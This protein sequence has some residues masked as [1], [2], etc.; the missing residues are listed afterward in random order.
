LI[1]FSLFN[2]LGYENINVD[3]F[4]WYERTENFF[5]AIKE[6]DFSDT[7]QQYHPGV[8]LMYLIRLGQLSYRISTGDFSNHSDIS[9]ENYGLYNYHTKL[10]VVIFCLLIILFSSHLVNK[11][12]KSKF[13]AI[14]FFIFLLLESYYIGI[15]RNLHMDGI[16]SVLIFSSILSF[17]LA[18]SEKSTKYFILSGIL[19]GLGFLT[20]SVSFFIPLFCLIIFIV[21]LIK[22][23]NSFSLFMRMG[24][25]WI[26]ISIF[27]FVLLFPAMWVAP[28]DT[29]SRIIHDGVL[30]TGVSGSFN[31]YLNN[32][33]TEDPG[34]FFY[35]KVLA[36]RITPFTHFL[37]LVYFVFLLIS[38]FRKKL[39]LIPELSIL[40]L[41][42]SALYFLVF[43]CLQKKT[44]R[45]M[46]SIYPFLALI[47]AYSFSILIDFL[48]NL[49]VGKKI[50]N[51]FVLFIF[52]I[53]FTYYVWNIFTLKP[54]F[55]AYYNHVL[56]GIDRAQKE[57]YLN[58]GGIGVFE[59]SEYLDS[60]K[61]SDNTRIAV[62]NERELQKV[63]K[64]QLEPPY[65]HL[66]DEYDLV[67][68]PLQKDGFF[69][70]KRNII[71]TFDIQNQVYWRI[72]SD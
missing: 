33:M 55:L 15:L 42:F 2:K 60:L 23:R 69:E 67:I 53:S 39:K 45:Y 32:T 47:S 51:F 59:I 10:Y 26:L 25:L 1:Y 62:T 50:K 70:W 46:S 30:D 22:E 24:I 63:T 68:V 49:R 52:V 8:T 20:K 35:V 65:P 61:L 6:G 64:Y 54:Y 5:Q 11:I 41:F 14:S 4:L 27:V 44:D 58:Q 13:I 57:M 3:Q 28:I 29:L 48:K 34:I 21:F 38:L 31:H 66:K 18:C 71:K 12:T 36:F 9:Y 43:T 40:S 16:L 37:I 72:Y 19:T 17:Y 56:G 7:Y